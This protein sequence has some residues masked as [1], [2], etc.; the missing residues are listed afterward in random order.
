MASLPFP[1]YGAT[2]RASQPYRRVSFDDAAA[3]EG[4][5]IGRPRTT[6]SLSEASYA[7]AGSAGSYENLNYH[8]RGEVEVPLPGDLL[9]SGDG[10]RGPRDVPESQKWISL[11][12]LWAFMGPGWLMSIAY[13]DPGNLESD[14]QAG[15]YTGYQL[16]SVLFW[17]TAG[18]LLLQILAARLG[19]VTGRHM[20]EL[21]RE[22]Y[23]RPVVFGLWIACEIAIV[24][25]DIQEVVGSAVALEILFGIPLWA[26]CLVTALDTFTFLGLHYF[27]VRRLEAF[28][29]ALII[30]MVGCFFANFVLA[31]PP[32]AKILQATAVP[33]MS[34]YALL[35]AVGLVGA[36]IMPHNIYL[37]SAL[38]QTRRVDRTDPEHVALAN[39]YFGLEAALA[40]LCS[41]LINAAVVAVFSKGFYDAACAP[42]GRACVFERSTPSSSP[43]NLH[44]SPQFCTT[45]AGRRGVC[46]EIGLADAG[47]A[48]MQLLG[49]SARTVWAVGLLAAGQS[50]TMTGTYAGQ[51]VMQGFLE[52]E[53]MPW[54][55][56]ALTRAAALGPAVAVVLYGAAQ[57]RSAAD[58]GGG[59]N[60]RDEWRNVL[61]SVQLPFALLP[62]LQFTDSERIMGPR[63]VNSAALSRAGW[64]LTG[65]V[66]LCN[67][68][69]VG[70]Q[71]SGVRWGVQ[72]A[73]V[74]AAWIA[75]AAV[76]L[77]LLARLATLGGTRGLE[78]KTERGV[79]GDGVGSLR[80]P[81]GAPDAHAGSGGSVDAST[82][83]ARA[84]SRL[85]AGSGGHAGPSSAAGTGELPARPYA[86]SRVAVQPA[87]G[88]GERRS[89]NS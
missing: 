71:L 69:L 60:R 56:V 23:P 77:A 65:G 8:I 68:V 48:L 34:P 17:A 45:A 33:S 49:G 52:L 83:Q 11:R 44:K 74:I 40:L 32:A 89:R 15:A 36:V 82:W 63:F 12:L 67:V 31:A 87:R 53:L 84:A 6:R 51:F 35:Q 3:L 22:E 79:C 61:Q 9:P 16:L 73:W 80:P 38:V 24:G 72:P 1:S 55:R 75:V 30:V 13:L 2:S 39:K 59:L 66:V 37:H 26:G 81:F 5:R 58:G 86:V 50:S 64:A 54:V 7:S 27:G 46:G 85:D 62:L 14:L 29:G 88:E 10:S 76:Y 78:Q 19:V 4:P 43:H 57:S 70:Q 20:A 28:F 25:S 47:D 18:G 42:T 21:C 41:F